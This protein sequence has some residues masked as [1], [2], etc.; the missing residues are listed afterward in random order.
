MPSSASA[1]TIAGSDLGTS[2][3]FIMSVSIAPTCSAVT[4]IPRSATSW[5]SPLVMDHAADF[6]AQYPP[7]AGR[8]SQDSTDSTFSSAP[9]PLRSITGTKARATARVPK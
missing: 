5:R 7:A 1:A 3:P 8:L 9:P 2:A 6:E 4:V